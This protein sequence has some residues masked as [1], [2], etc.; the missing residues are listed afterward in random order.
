MCRVVENAYLLGTHFWEHEMLEEAGGE[1]VALY[2]RA[3]CHRPL[4]GI[5]NVLLSI[6]AQPT[7][8][9]VAGNGP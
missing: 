9:D 8:G 6:S 1:F 7:P 5:I 2:V 4:H 3:P